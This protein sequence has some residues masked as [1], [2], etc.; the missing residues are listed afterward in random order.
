[1]TLATTKVSGDRF[2]DIQYEVRWNEELVLTVGFQLQM[3][4]DNLVYVTLVPE[5]GLASTPPSF[6]RAVR[7]EFNYWTEGYRLFCQT[8]T[9]VAC[10]F[11]QFFGFRVSEIQ[12][13]TTIMELK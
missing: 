10:R 2:S 3:Q 13:S 8:E 6:W 9:E 4:M 1:M 5:P 12:H 7:A 11:A